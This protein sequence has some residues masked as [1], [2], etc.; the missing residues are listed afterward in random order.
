MKAIEPSLSGKFLS[1]R[2][3]ALELT[4]E[5]VKLLDQT[6]LPGKVSYLLIHTAPE[7]ADAIETMLVRGAPA[8]GIA[9]A[10]GVVLSARHYTSHT[11]LTLNAMREAIA[12]DAEMLART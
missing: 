3:Q 8:I 7:M 12:S 1:S 11:E 6:A 2:V 5:G 4:P 10:Y 9:G